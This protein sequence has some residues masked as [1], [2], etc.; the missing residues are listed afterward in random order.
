MNHEI[1]PRVLKITQTF[2]AKE[3]SISSWMRRMLITILSA[4]TEDA[5][6]LDYAV[7]LSRRQI[8]VVHVV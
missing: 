3:D 6:F 1:M 5:H 7:F 4:Q 8:F 2:I